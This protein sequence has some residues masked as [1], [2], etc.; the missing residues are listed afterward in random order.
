M[1]LEQRLMRL[2][3]HMLRLRM[4]TVLLLLGIVA[5]LG[6]QAAYIVRQ[7]QKARHAPAVAEFVQARRFIVMDERGQ[8]S[9]VL[10]SNREGAYLVLN[11]G[12]GRKRALLDVRETGPGLTL[13]DARGTVR[14]LLAVEG[15]GPFFGLADQE[16]DD[17]FRAP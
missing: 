6:L 5:S 2:E 13:H 8:E 17:L 10:A 7:W 4:L 16:G 14:A 3:R 11:D 12:V 9:A 15:G 1:E